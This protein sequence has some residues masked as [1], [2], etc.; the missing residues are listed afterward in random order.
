MKKTLTSL[1]LAA[2]ALPSFVMA[3]NSAQGIGNKLNGISQNVKA[4]QLS[5]ENMKLVDPKI[6]RKK[7]FSGA[8]GTNSGGGGASAE[9]S[10]GQR[11]LL[12]LIEQDELTY[13][14]PDEELKKTNPNFIP[15]TWLLERSLNSYEKIREGRTWKHKENE[16]IGDPSFLFNIMYAI[17]AQFTGMSLKSRQLLLNRYNIP[18][19]Q[20]LKWAF[21][22]E[23]LGK[24]NDE[25]LI[26]IENEATKRQ[27]AVQKDGFVLINRQEYQSMDADSQ[28]VLFF[29]ESVLRAVL[30]LNPGH[31]ESHGT[32]YVRAYTRQL[33]RYLVRYYASGPTLPAFPVREAY[34][35]FQIQ[36]QS[37]YWNK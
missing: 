32:Q 28:Y 30:L 17:D 14:F 11:R 34:E 7:I 24:L 6:L 21:T 9:D 31:I 19:A 23:D 4:A 36:E 12:D 10:N 27:V 25:G 8:I 29:H 1:I 37:S 33:F 16:D 3:G 2:I 20:P 35:A 5:P 22:D 18:L 26:S 13:F 15:L